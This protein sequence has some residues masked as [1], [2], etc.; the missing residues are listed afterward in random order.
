MNLMNEGLAMEL[1]KDVG[2]RPQEEPE[3][4]AGTGGQNAGLYI[5]MW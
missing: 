4:A 1:V 2:G 5:S 3:R